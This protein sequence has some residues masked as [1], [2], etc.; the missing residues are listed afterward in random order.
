MTGVPVGEARALAFVVLVIAN[1]VLV[2][3]SRSPDSGWR[4][5]FTRLPSVAA[6]VLGGTLVALVIVT[7][8]PAV[9]APFAFSPPAIQQWLLAATIGLAMLLLFEG[10]KAAFRRRH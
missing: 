5:S 2:L 4:E 6:W 1:A 9:S 7:G 10:V 3:P 8:V